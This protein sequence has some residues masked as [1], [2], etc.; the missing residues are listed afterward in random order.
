MGVAV[1]GCSTEAARAEEL[2]DAAKQGAR[3]QRLVAA[4]SLRVRRLP[5]AEPPCGE[6]RQRPR[7]VQ[8]ERGGAHTAQPPAARVHGDDD[9]SNRSN[10]V[11]C[12]L[13]M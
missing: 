1:L 12:P 3:R 7:L 6:G 8:L 13:R 9:T 2:E 11:Y 5:A 4:L 10:Y